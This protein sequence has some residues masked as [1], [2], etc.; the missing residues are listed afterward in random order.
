VGALNKGKAPSHQE[1]G[2]LQS[3]TSTQS[4]S[5]CAKSNSIASGLQAFVM[6]NLLM[7]APPWP[8]VSCNH[9]VSDAALGIQSHV[10][11]TYLPSL[12]TDI[13]ISASDSA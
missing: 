12:F 11:G 4:S 9:S 6:I 13:L 8:L 7:T 1:A 5:P 2:S 3:L 10:I